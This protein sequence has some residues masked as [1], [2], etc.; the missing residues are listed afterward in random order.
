MSNE[1]IVT[2]PAPPIAP[3]PPLTKWEREYQA[4][5]QLLP[6][7]LPTHR[8]R[9]VAVHDG[10]VIDADDDRLALIFRALE[11]VG[12]VDIHV[13]FVTDQAQPPIRIPHYRVVGER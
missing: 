9:Y 3:A 1:S 13:G 10:Q 7:L 6:T 8:G 11:K 5:H 2:L 12:N 4:F